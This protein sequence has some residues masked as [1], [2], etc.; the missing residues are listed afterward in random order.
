MHNESVFVGSF[1]FSL[2]RK[3]FHDS[4]RLCCGFLEAAAAALAEAHHQ[5]HSTM[6]RASEM[7]GQ[8]ARESNAPTKP[9]HSLSSARM[10]LQDHSEM[11][12]F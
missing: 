6:H 11:A 4:G 8:R 7:P 9:N 5:L 3:S 2:L 12:D 10:C 1:V